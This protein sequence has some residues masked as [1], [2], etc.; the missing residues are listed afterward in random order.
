M[1]RR[2]SYIFVRPNRSRTAMSCRYWKGRISQLMGLIVIVTIW[3]GGVSRAGLYECRDASGAPIYT[4]SPAQLER[5]QPVASGGTS[6]LGLVGGSSPSSAQT[7]E[8]MPFSQPAATPS[9]MPAD[10]VGGA[11]APTGGIIPPSTGL[12][13]VASGS[14]EPPP[15]TAG[16]NPLNPLSGPPC[17]ITP[18]P[19]IPTDPA[20]P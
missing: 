6:R 3:M 17:P 18:A 12:Q 7:A 10:P 19:A 11:I 4:D 13:G 1:P 15:C 9:P 16:I 2:A 5:C 8:P 20:K 14:P